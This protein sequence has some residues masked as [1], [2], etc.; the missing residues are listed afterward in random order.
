M[1]PAIDCDAYR[2]AYIGLLAKGLIQY[3]SDTQ[4]FIITDAGFA[5]LGVTPAAPRATPP[6][7]AA[8][9]PGERSPAAASTSTSWFK[10]FIR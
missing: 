10:L 6:A 7:R 3:G 2:R 8:S 9:R 5:G 4:A 1:W